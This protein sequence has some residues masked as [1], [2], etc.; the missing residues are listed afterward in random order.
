MAKLMEFDFYY[1]AVW[2]TLLNNGVCPV[3]IEGGCDRQIYRITTDEKETLLFV[4]YRSS[5]NDTKKEDYFSWSF[6]FSDNDLRELNDLLKSEREFSLGLVC[7]ANKLNQSQYVVL[8][9]KD[10]RELFSQGKT[11]LTV[12]R[13]KNE[14]Y[15]RVSIGG[16]RDNSLK[17][18]ANRIY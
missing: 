16:G 8:D 10:I 1:G 18:K 11:S 17:I 9:R 12:S 7:G 2:S 14:R 13:K 5:P 6:V 4:K 15:F 3:L